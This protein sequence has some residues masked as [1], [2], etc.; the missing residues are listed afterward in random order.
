[1][2]SKAKKNKQRLTARQRAALEVRRLIA[3]S[4]AKFEAAYSPELRELR[5][6]AKRLQAALRAL[7]RERCQV[8]AGTEL[9]ADLAVAEH[10]A[11]AAFLA[12]QKQSIALWKQEYP[13]VLERLTGEP[14]AATRGRLG[15][16]DRPPT[17][18]QGPGDGTT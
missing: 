2:T 10:H 1:M 5:A 11:R 12:V 15:L 14:A 3:E 13:L 4:R 6:R 9:R 7:T 18:F 16:T 8:V 17:E